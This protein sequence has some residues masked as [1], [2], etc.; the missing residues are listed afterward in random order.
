MIKTIPN[1]KKYTKAKLLSEEAY[2]YLKRSKKTRKK[3]RIT[4]S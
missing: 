4:P 1:K 3:G 2:R